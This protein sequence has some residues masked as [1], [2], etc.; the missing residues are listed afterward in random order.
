MNLNFNIS[1]TYY[2]DG[3]IVDAMKNKNWAFEVE[4]SDST[5]KIRTIISLDQALEL[6]DNIDK[7]VKA[8]KQACALSGTLNDLI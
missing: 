4:F 7:A 2:G 6:R 1:P 5:S 8:H 3:S